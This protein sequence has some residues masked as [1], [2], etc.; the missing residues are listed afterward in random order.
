MYDWMETLFAYIRGLPEG[1]QFFFWLAVILLG[2]ALIGWVEQGLARRHRTN[3]LLDMRAGRGRYKVK[4]P[5]RKERR[6]LR[7]WQLYWRLKDRELE[8]AALKFAASGDCSRF[9]TERDR[10]PQGNSGNAERPA[11][12]RQFFID[13]GY[14]YPKDDCPDES[15]GGPR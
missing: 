5:T 1:A 14:K 10:V 2:L 8:A 6:A 15:E 12:N 11:L 9:M 7:Q 13:R 3:S 4:K